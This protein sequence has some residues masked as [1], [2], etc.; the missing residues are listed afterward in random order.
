ME[1]NV[2][3][4][5]STD[6]SVVAVAVG[7]LVELGLMFVFPHAPSSEVKSRTIIIKSDNL[8]V[9]EHLLCYLKTANF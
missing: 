6:G 3:S 7:F 4:I 8:F 1:T 2:S 9:I 5:G